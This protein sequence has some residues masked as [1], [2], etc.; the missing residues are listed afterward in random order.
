M[1]N[2]VLGHIRQTAGPAQCSTA[3]PLPNSCSRSVDFQLVG[4]KGGRGHDGHHREPPPP[5][6]LHCHQQQWPCPGFS[7]LLDQ[8]LNP[9]SPQPYAPEV[10]PNIDRGPT[11]GKKREKKMRKHWGKNARERIVMKGTARGRDERLRAEDLY[12]EELGV[13]ERRARV[14]CDLYLWG[15]PRP[16]KMALGN[17][18]FWQHEQ[19]HHRLRGASRKRTVCNSG[20]REA[21]VELWEGIHPRRRAARQMRHRLPSWQGGRGVGGAGQGIAGLTGFGRG[22]EFG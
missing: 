12:V 7:D 16:W 9:P 11:A 10:R 17:I 19:C 6:Q 13:K 8:A 4:L 2:K 14:L 5:S 1:V 20:G 18:P 22:R 3:S 21:G 15:A